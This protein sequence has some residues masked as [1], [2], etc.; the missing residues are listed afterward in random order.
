MANVGNDILLQLE[1]DEVRLLIALGYE[2]QKNAVCKHLFKILYLSWVNSIDLTRA[3]D[4][5]E[6]DAQGRIGSNIPPNY[7]TGY[8]AELPQFQ[9]TPTEQGNDPFSRFIGNIGKKR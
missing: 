5:K 6:R 1:Q 3:K 7:Q 9:P 2:G 8:G 4:G